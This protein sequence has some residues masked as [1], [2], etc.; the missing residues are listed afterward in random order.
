MTLYF[1]N[2]N[3]YYNRTLKKE[4]DKIGDYGLYIIEA[5][6]N[7]N[8]IPNDGITTT[9]IINWPA[10]QA[11]FPDYMLAWDEAN[12][13]E[14]T[15]TI[16]SRWFVI[17]SKRTR[18]GQYE[19]TLYRDLLADYFDELREAP[20]FVEKGPLAANS[21]LLFN[22]ENMTVNQ[23]RQKPTLLYDKTEC[24]WI[25][26]YI[27][28]DAFAENK[29]ISKTIGLAAEDADYE[30]EHIEDWEYA[31]L[32]GNPVY[33]NIVPT[34]R[35][36]YNTTEIRGYAKQNKSY[37]VSINPDSVSKETIEPPHQGDWEGSYTWQPPEPITLST[38]KNGLFADTTTKGY[39]DGFI[40]GTYTPITQAIASSLDDINGQIIK[41][42]TTNL[43]YSIRVVSEPFQE[44]K[45]LNA[46]N[47]L[48][49]SIKN[50]FLDSFVY[51]PTSGATTN[52]TFSIY[53]EGTR[54][55]IYLD[56]F[57]LTLSTT[58]G[59]DR[60]HLEDQPFDMFC[61]PYGEI[62]ISD[63]QTFGFASS[64]TAASIATEI[65]KDLGA[66]SVY[67]IQIL[68]YCPIPYAVSEGPVINPRR[69]KHNFITDGEGN[70]ISAIFWCR[71]S[72]FQ[73]ELPYSVPKESTAFGTKIASETKK[74]R[75]TSPNYNGAFDFDPQ[76]NGGVSAFK[77]DCTYKPFNPYIRVYP[78]FNGLYGYG[79]QYDA[80]GL[81]LGGD[82][83]LPRVESA[84][85]NYQE[86]NK[87]YNDIFVRKIESLEK[88]NNYQMA[89]DI[90]A[91]IAGS[92]QAMV[93]GGISGAMMGGMFGA[94]GGGAGMGAGAAIGAIAGSVAGIGSGVADVAINNALRKENLDLTIDQFGYELGNIQAIPTSLTKSSALAINNPLIPMLEVYECSQQ[95]T[96]AY[97]NKL[98]YNGFTVMTIGT[99]GEYINQ[100]VFGAGYDYFK[101]KL[102]RLEGIADDTHILNAIAAEL[103][104][105]VYL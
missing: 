87:N 10:T 32:V 94:G 43:Y 57:F 3:N 25:V 58:I 37:L 9:Q 97:I 70:N 77:A 80:R 48:R 68:P 29:T 79:G 61:I 4:G 60:Y 40:N 95:E 33:L 44:E 1:L 15:M 102:I 96:D 18:A 12:D 76:K 90:F 65:T 17:E 82:F 89:N 46:A 38:F 74:Y 62:T 93:S 64:R 51:P 63:D 56:Q 88:Q 8:F 98:R 24:P 103:N 72:S 53:S 5:F 26:G 100:P 86:Q 50:A 16:H 27:P 54:Y 2:Y 81:I 42:T 83:S 49:T 19:M 99:M 69:I 85:A 28:S 104:K 91:S 11:S 84:W 22:N 23:I 55:T 31:S 39:I 34:I 75:L 52:T 105:G 13:T 47:T 35:A 36:R 14:F 92:G 78:V 21:P 41:D 67:D 7:V 30:V 45:M 71:S 73:V 101:G 59:P 66:G 20:I 6:P